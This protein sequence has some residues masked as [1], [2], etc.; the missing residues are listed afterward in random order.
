MLQKFCSI[1]EKRWCLKSMKQFWITSKKVI[2]C[3]VFAVRTQLGVCLMRNVALYDG[4]C[5]TRH[6][7]VQECMGL[8]SWSTDQVRT[9]SC[10][11]RRNTCCATRGAHVQCLQS[12]AGWFWPHPHSISRQRMPCLL[13]SAQNLLDIILSHHQIGYCKHQFYNLFLYFKKWVKI[14]EILD[15]R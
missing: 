5:N 15:P 11:C 6:H 12:H 9:T 7:S 14:V 2:S 8:I 13:N 4:S 10:D 1:G 3:Q